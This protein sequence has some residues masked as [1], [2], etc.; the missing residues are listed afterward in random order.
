M[1]AEKE[2]LVGCE[3]VEVPLAGPAVLLDDAVPGRAAEHRRPVVRR[4]TAVRTAAVAEDVPL[5]LR[6][7]RRRGERLLEPDVL[8]GAVVGDQVDGDFD[9]EAVGLGDHLVE[10][11]QRAEDRVDVARVGDVVAV[12]GHRGAV[13]RVQPECVDAEV[14]Q[15]GETGLQTRQIPYAVAVRVGETPHV[16]LVEHGIA[17]PRASQDVPPRVPESFQSPHAARASRVSTGVTSPQ[18]GPVTDQ[19]CAARPC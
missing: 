13:E 2:T 19:I 4:L 6:A 18:R 15:V 5:P 12:V 14:G 9:A 8:V 16:D 1:S 3:Q 10:V 11:R 7:A 17:P